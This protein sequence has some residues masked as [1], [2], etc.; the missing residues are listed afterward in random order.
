MS[1]G[2]ASTSAS[3]VSFRVSTVQLIISVYQKRYNPE[4]PFFK[5]GRDRPFPQN[6]RK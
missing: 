6:L 3:T 2:K 4:S 5:A 1:S